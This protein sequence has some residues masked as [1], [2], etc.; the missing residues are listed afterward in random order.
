MSNASTRKDGGLYLFF[1]IIIVSLISGGL[2]TAFV[3]GEF[4]YLLT[5][6][7]NLNKVPISGQVSFTAKVRITYVNGE[8]QKLE[9][10]PDST[11]LETDAKAPNQPSK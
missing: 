7:V 5:K 2:S 3:K 8:Q 10:V 1:I 9:L 6:E 11:V 4:K